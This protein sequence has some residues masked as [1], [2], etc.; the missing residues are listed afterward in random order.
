MH[1]T[2]NIYTF[3]ISND[4]TC[5]MTDLNSPVAH[6]YTDN[7]DSKAARVKLQMFRGNLSQ[8]SYRTS[9]VMKSWLGKTS[10]RCL[11]S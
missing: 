6:F 1:Y 10:D 5:I 9:S 11:I 4:Y 7:L 8:F 2:A 3:G